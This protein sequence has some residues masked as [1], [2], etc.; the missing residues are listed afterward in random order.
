VAE[1]LNVITGATGLLGSHVAEQLVARGERGRT[2][3]RRDSNI[4]FLQQ[5]GVELAWGDLQDP[6]SLREAFAGADVVYHC[7]AKVG[8]WG[9]RSVYQA[10]IIDATRNVV[11]ACRAN[12]VGRLLHVSSITVYGHLHGRTGPFTEDEPLGQNLWRSDNYIRAKIAAEELARGYAPNVTIIRP[13]WIYGPR[14][15]NT[16]PLILLALGAGLVVI[17]GPGVTLLNL[18]YVGDVAEAAILAANSPVSRGQAYNLSSAGELTQQQ[19]L[20]MLTDALGLPRARRHIPFRIAFWLGHFAE[21]VGR[22]IRMRRP[23]HITRYAVSL[24]GRPTQFSIAKARTQLGWQ[25]RVPVQEAL[26]RT[27][28][29]VREMETPA[30]DKKALAS[31]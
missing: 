4:A 19:L 7:A 9:P 1:K 15:R 13:S 14:D 10:Q 6:A 30:L 11:D 8:E 27:L 22:I 26:R 29:W 20:N 31:R 21:I 12:A 2:L 23:P 16:M 5:L 25:P 28:E 24:V 17:I 3:V 18:V